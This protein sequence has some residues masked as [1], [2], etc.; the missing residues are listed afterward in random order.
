MPKDAP[1]PP[2]WMHY[3]EHSDVDKAAKMAKE[4]GAQTFVPPTDIPNMGRFAVFA[5][6]TGA[7]FAVFQSAR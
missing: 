7:H 4:L 1:H 6:P 5:D 2:Y 3:V